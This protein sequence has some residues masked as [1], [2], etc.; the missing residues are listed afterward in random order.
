MIDIK[1]KLKALEGQTFYTVTGKAF[2]FEFVGENTIKVSRT[3]YP[4]HLSNFEKALNINPAKP[5]DLT[6]A[7][8]ESSYIFAIITDKRFG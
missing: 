1:N 4:I 8:R 2:V 3:A 6:D 5:S 7:V